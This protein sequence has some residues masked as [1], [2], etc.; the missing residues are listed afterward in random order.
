[1]RRKNDV[2]VRLLTAPNFRD[3][4]E[5]RALAARLGRGVH[6]QSRRLTAL[7]HAREKAIVFAS[8]VETE[9]LESRRTEHLVDARVSGEAVSDDA[10]G[11]RRTQSI[12]QAVSGG[13]AR[14]PKC[15]YGI[16]LRANPRLRFRSSVLRPLISRAT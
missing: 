5:H 4:V 6:P 16:L 9:H 15:V 8:N 10:C 1:M 7:D 12:L 14:A 11:T 2:L 3:R 13:D